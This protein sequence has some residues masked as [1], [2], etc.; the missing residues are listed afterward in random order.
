MATN[1]LAKLH[2]SQLFVTL[3]F[4]TEIE[5]RYVNMR[6]NST[7]DASTSCKNFVNFGCHSNVD[8]AH[9]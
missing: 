3:A 1:F 2:S 4:Q 5:Y 8:R 6:V 9:L 7:N